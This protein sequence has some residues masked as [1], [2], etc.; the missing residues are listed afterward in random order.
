[1]KKINTQTPEELYDE[2]RRMLLINRAATDDRDAVE[3]RDDVQAWRDL[4]YGTPELAHP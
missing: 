1:M 3:F 4:V 2:N